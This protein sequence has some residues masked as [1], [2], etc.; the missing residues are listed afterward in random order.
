M[1]GVLQYGNDGIPQS[2]HRSFVIGA[3]PGQ[4]L[5]MF[6]EPRHCFSS[7]LS[8]AVDNKNVYTLLLIGYS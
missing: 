6:P 4:V 2:R 3:A 8:V 7:Y 1:F 5:P